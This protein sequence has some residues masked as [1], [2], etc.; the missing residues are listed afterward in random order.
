MVIRIPSKIEL[1]TLYTIVNIS[2]QFQENHKK[3]KFESNQRLIKYMYIFT[4]W[5]L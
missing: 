2:W 3:H 1:S 4:F 5:S